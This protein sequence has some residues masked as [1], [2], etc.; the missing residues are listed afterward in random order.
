[1]LALV[2]R[3][4]LFLTNDTGPMHVAAAF[5]V[6][7]VAVFGPT[8]WQTTSPFGVDAQLVRQ[9][10][11]CAPCLLRECPIDHR[12]MTGVTVEQVHSAAVRHLPLAAP[13]PV[14]EPDAAGPALSPTALAGVTVFLDR[15]G[16]LNAD[17]G[18]VKSPEAFT[19][20][21]GVGAAL[22][23]LKQGGARLVVVTNQSGVGR[24]YFSVKDLEAIHTKLRLLL[25]EAGVTLDA[26]YFCPHHP[27]DRCHCRKPARGMVDRALAELQVE[28]S[29]AYVVGDSARDVELAKQV[30]ARA[31]LVMTGPS[32]AEALADLT[33]RD[34]SP[35]HV[36]ADLEEAAN[37]IVAHATRKPGADV[38]R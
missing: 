10:V 19:L 33:A 27:D 37:W 1:L 22:A 34:L 24:G 28:L 15:D 26:L 17:T 3:C 13:L 14:H 16:T 7:L 31:V 2:K 12:C 23:A 8:D 4:Q 5:N 9:P 38:T 30:G 11:S 36:A 18:Y 32:G 20:L 6:P 25:A 35:D 29:R 21:P